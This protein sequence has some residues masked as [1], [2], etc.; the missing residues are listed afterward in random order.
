MYPQNNVS[1]IP[2]QIIHNIV[3]D[4][5]GLVEE[6]CRVGLRKLER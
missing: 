3:L 4:L 5:F 2:V 6:Y 1:E